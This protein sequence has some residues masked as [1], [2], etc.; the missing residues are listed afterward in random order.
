LDLQTTLSIPLCLPPTAQATLEGT[1]TARTSGPQPFSVISGFTETTAPQGLQD[2][3]ERST[4]A[5]R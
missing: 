4:K 5:F 3:W 1:V 2:Q